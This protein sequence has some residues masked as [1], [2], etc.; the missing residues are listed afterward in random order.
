MNITK[1]LRFGGAIKLPRSAATESKGF[2]VRP[3]RF[4][5]PTFCS[6]GTIVGVRGRVFYDLHWL[7]R[8][9]QRSIR[10]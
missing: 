3:G 4:E 5:R 7:I 8:G 1:H 9:E 6:G 10:R 2:V